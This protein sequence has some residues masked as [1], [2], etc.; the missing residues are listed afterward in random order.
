MLVRL[1]AFLTC[2]FLIG[3]S[4]RT[5]RPIVVP[6]T[7]HDES[8]LAIPRD[9]ADEHMLAKYKH[10]YEE[11]RH[12]E[13]RYSNL[14]IEQEARLSQD[15]AN[16][17][18]AFNYWLWFVTDSVKAQ[19][20]LEPPGSDIEPGKHP[21]HRPYVGEYRSRAT[22]ALSAIRTFD[23]DLRDALHIPIPNGRKKGHPSFLGNLG[24]DGTFLSLL[25]AQTV[26]YGTWELPRSP[27]SRAHVAHPSRCTFPRPVLTPP[28]GAKTRRALRSPAAHTDAPH[29]APM[30]RRRTCKLRG[31]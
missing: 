6:A 26:W 24:T 15:Y 19:S 30:C 10:H 27:H 23:G 5:P 28:R 8:V 20:E 4:T 3:C 31:G 21:T 11:F 2:G 16:A 18:D 9:T 29:S 14:S 17:S 25:N 13:N 7:P 1:T 22:E 12:V